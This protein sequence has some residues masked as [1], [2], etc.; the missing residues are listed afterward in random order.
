MKGKNTVVAVRQVLSLFL[1]LNIVQTEPSYL[2]ILP[3]FAVV[4]SSCPAS[5]KNIKSLSKSCND[6]TFVSLQRVM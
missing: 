1:V 6:Y 4:A 3:N 2:A 5:W